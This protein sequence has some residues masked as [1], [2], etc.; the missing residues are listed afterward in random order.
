MIIYPDIPHLDRFGW[1]R[2]EDAVPVRLCERL[3]E[4]LV[5]EMDVPA[6]V[7]IC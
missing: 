7:K 1:M 5:A 2:V 4:V 3:V 6:H